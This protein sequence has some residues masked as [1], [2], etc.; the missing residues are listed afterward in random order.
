MVVLRF[1]HVGQHFLK[2]GELA[3]MS[4]SKVIH[5]DQNAGLLNA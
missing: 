3:G 1:T 4:I 2:K 5:F